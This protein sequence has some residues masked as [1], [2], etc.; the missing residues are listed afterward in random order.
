M[1]YAFFHVPAISSVDA[2]VELNR[3]LASRRIA[4]IEKH[5]VADGPNSFWAICVGYVDGADATPVGGG[6]DKVDYKQVLPEKEF[7]LFVKLRELRKRLADQEGVPAYAIFTNEQM[8]EMVRRKPPSPDS[9][10]E[11]AGIGKVR[12]EKYGAQ[13]LAILA[14]SDDAREAPQ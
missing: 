3:L 10:A 12:A 11:I 1:R 2:G 14:G 5:F 6:K 7:A 4:G 9:I 8:A 13:F